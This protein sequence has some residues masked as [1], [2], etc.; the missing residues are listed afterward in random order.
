MLVTD[1]ILTMLFIVHY[2]NPNNFK[3]SRVFNSVEEPL[4]TF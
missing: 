4:M 3:I 1:L 2:L